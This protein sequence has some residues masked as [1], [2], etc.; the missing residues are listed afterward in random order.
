MQICIAKCI[1]LAWIMLAYS[2]ENL[3]HISSL[4]YIQTDILLPAGMHEICMPSQPAMHGMQ[5]PYYAYA[6]A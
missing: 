5:A 3:V 1:Y 2:Q 4:Q 6:Y